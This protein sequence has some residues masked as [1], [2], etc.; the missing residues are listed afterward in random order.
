MPTDIQILLGLFRE[1]SNPSITPMT[2]EVILDFIKEIV[3]RKDE[4]EH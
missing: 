2:I 3:V 1:M 4:T